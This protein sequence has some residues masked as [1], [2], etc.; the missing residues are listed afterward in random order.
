[1]RNTCLKTSRERHFEAAGIK[2]RIMLS[3]NFQE[4][5]FTYEMDRAN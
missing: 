4:S 5:C 1:M 2:G 3:C